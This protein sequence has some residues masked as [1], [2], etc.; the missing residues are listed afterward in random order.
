MSIRDTSLHKGKDYD[1]SLVGYGDGLGTDYTNW[2]ANKLF[3]CSC[4][5]GFFGPDCSLGQTSS[6]LLS[7]LIIHFSL[8]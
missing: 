4:D 6:I 1:T 8:Q 2:E 3:M 7:N 5:T